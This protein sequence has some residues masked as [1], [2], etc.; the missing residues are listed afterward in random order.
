MA[1]EEKIL[2]PADIVLI[3]GSYS[4]CHFLEDLIDLKI[5]LY[6]PAE[7][8][9]KRLLLRDDAAFLEKWH[10]R[11]DAVESYYFEQIRPNRYFDWIIAG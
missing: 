3:E 5:L 6:V 10:K 1:H 7:E 4:A 9:H 2:N 8:R 11:W